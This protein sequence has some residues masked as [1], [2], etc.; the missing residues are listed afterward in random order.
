MKANIIWFV[1]QQR[2]QTQMF[3][4]RQWRQTS[5][6]LLGEMLLVK[7]AHMMRS[8]SGIELKIVHIVMV[9]QLDSSAV[10]RVLASREKGKRDRAH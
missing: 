7:R 5:E 4:N 6:T 9:A 10:L 2:T 1:C 8:S 3:S